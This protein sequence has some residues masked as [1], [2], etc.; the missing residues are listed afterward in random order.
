MRLDSFLEPI[1][2]TPCNASASTP[3]TH[4][5]AHA[6]TGECECLATELPHT[7][8]RG[9]LLHAGRSACQV[10]LWCLRHARLF[11]RLARL[12]GIA[13]SRHASSLTTPP[14]ACL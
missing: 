6:G 2:C 12:A 9:C 5:S 14:F 4:E 10:W 3:S 1:N 11:G 7:H 13:V 8:V